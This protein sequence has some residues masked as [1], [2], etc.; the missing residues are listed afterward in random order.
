MYFIILLNRCNGCQFH[1]VRSRI[2]INENM[3]FTGGK[4]CMRKHDAYTKLY[5]VYIFVVFIVTLDIQC[6]WKAEIPKDVII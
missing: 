6:N 3:H 5:T 2:V 4:I 1:I